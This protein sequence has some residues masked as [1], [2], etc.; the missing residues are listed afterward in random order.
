MVLVGTII[1]HSSNF[2]FS[3][4]LCR[5]VATDLSWKERN[6]IQFQRGNTK[7]SEQHAKETMLKVARLLKGWIGKGNKVSRELESRFY[8]ALIE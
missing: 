2:S 4:Q 8:G 7:I 5:V 3:W 1:N 6:C